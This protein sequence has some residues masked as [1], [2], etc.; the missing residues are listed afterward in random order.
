LINITQVTFPYFI[1]C[2]EVVFSSLFI[3]KVEIVDGD[4]LNCLHS[5]TLFS[6]RSNS[7]II[8]T[9]SR[10]DW[11]FLLFTDMLL[12]EGHNLHWLICHE[13]LSTV[14]S[15]LLEWGSREDKVFAN[16][17]KY[18]RSETPSGP[19]LF[20]ISAKRV[21]YKREIFVLKCSST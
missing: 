11:H 19:S 17:G 21:R 5:S 6:P 7:R 12:V 9:F 3:H 10:I 2:S 16:P 20:D 13:P 15:P 8:S 4:K 14:L 1:V 18:N